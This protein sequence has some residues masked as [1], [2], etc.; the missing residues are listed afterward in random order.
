MV[1]EKEAKTKKEDTIEVAKSGRAK[2][3]GCGDKIEKGA[4]RFGLV[5]FAFSESGSHR[6]FHLACV[7]TKAGERLHALL[8]QDQESL[9][10]HRDAISAALGGTPKPA[11]ASAE[12]GADPSRPV[13]SKS[14]WP[15]WLAKAK[16]PKRKIPH[17]VRSTTLPV[18]QGGEVL[19]AEACI[20]LVGAMMKDKVDKPDKVL[21]EFRGWLEPASYRRFAWELFRGWAHAD[22]HM[23]QSWVIRHVASVVDDD[24][25][26]P[27]GEMI[28]VLLE[29]KKR[30]AV[31]EAARALC[32]HGT[33]T[34]LQVVQRLAQRYKYRGN[35]NPPLAVLKAEAAKRG[36][37][38][39]DLEDI[40][41]PTCGLDARGKRRFNYGPRT[42]TL[43]VDGDMRISV[44]AD[45]DGTRLPRLPK[46]WKADDAEKVQEAQAEFAR[47]KRDIEA[48]L[49]V[50]ARRLEGALSTGR[51]WTL[52]AWTK[53][54]RRHPLMQIIARR[55][56][57]VLYKDDVRVKSFRFDEQDELTDAGDDPCEFAL[58]EGR[59]RI[60]HPAEMSVEER[61]AWDV[62]FRDYE[63]MPPFPQLARPSF[64]LG[65]EE[66]AGTTLTS[67]RHEATKVGPLHGRF[68]RAA[69]SKGFV[70]DY[71]RIR[72]F[73]KEFAQGIRATAHLDPGFH[74]AGYDDAPQRITHVDFRASSG[75]SVLTL[76][77]VPRAIIS[78]VIYNMDQVAG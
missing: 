22:A 18:T 54:V 21:A 17:W 4:L 13:L 31:Y 2:C 26:A 65:E 6:W 60:A 77:D 44:V 12:T 71:A 72:T 28:E 73:H 64:T 49:P 35:N 30:D 66:R 5:D 15:P 11:N 3:R 55:L 39:E 56:I 40:S 50:Q 33:P 10:P 8:V 37:T 68:N 53:S 19:D 62:L 76:K 20:L 24:L 48:M 47:L 32:A 78:E 74:P 14:D 46:A 43:Q 25:A 58:T 27:L 57:W 59:V 67:F 63:I 70:D 29:K 45:D 38:L 36:V 52:S 1:D 9:A 34:S 51:E 75:R 23:V 7:Q 69:W 16:A 42:F 61:T 41:V